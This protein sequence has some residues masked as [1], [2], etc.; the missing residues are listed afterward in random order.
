MNFFKLLSLRFMSGSSLSA[1]RFVFEKF[2]SSDN[3]Y[4]HMVYSA[5]FSFLL[6]Q[7]A[8]VADARLMSYVRAQSLSSTSLR[9]LF[10]FSKSS[11]TLQ[12][13]ILCAYATDCTLCLFSVPYFLQ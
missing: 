4:V 9:D 5:L 10:L 12:A 8:I 13:I 6:S 1:S 7:L 11:S 2:L 3:K